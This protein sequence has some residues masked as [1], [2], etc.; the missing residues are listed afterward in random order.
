MD[1][2]LKGDTTRIINVYR[3]PGGS[4]KIFWDQM[5]LLPMEINKKTI[6][7]GDFNMDPS[8][9][10]VSNVLRELGFSQ[11]V[12]GHSHI[13][14]RTLDHF[15]IRPFKS[16]THHFMHPLYFSDH[17]AVCVSLKKEDD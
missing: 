8:N 14:G 9:N 16:I 3:P 12:R 6:I 5:R 13:K 4:M 7:C 10:M 17:N 1:V 11:I 2:E 15:Y